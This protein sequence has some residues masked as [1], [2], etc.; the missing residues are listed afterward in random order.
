MAEFYFLE[1]SLLKKLDVFGWD[2]IGQGE[3]I[4][5]DTAAMAS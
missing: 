2:V 1:K 4:P 5:K 3:G